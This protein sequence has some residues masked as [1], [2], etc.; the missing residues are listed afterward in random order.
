MTQPKIHVSLTM[1]CEFASLR[2]N[3]HGAASIEA[4]SLMRDIKD[5][6]LKFNM[7]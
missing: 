7:I 6:I 5:F 2:E 3:P 4:S 1:K